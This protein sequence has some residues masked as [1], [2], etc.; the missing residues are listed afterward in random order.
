MAVILRRSRESGKVTFFGR[1]MKADTKMVVNDTLHQE[2]DFAGLYYTT[3]NAEGL[4]LEPPYNPATLQALVSRNNSLSQC[5]EVMEVNIDGT[6]AT[7]EP[8]NPEK[9]G[10][11]SDKAMLEAFFKE[12]APAMDM[13]T[14]RKA[15]RW[16]VEATG[17]AYVE[18]L[19]N[20]EGK[21][22]FLR[23]LDTT[24]M[25][26]LKLDDPVLVDKEVM[27]GTERIKAKVWVRERRY[28]QKV[29][30]TKLYFK[31]FGASRDLN[32]YTGQW[33][34]LN[35]LP[36]EDRAS[37]VYHFTVLKDTKSPYG[38]PRWINNLPSV[39]GGRKSEEFNLQ[40]FDAGGVPPAAIFI[41]GGAVAK[42]VKEQLNGYFGGG[43][44]GKHRVALVEIESTSGAI[45]TPGNVGIKVERFGSDRTSDAM[46]Q[47][48]E[49]NTEQRIRAAFRLPAI[50]FGL[51][52][53]YNFATASMAY[54]VTEAQVFGPERN[55][56]DG[57]VNTQIV[58]KNFG[59]E[60]W[61]YVSTP[62]TLTNVD[63]QLVALPIIQNM[64]D[65]EELV[66]TVNEITGM[67]LEYSEETD[68]ANK[69]RLS[70]LMPDGTPKPLPMP[71]QGPI[72]DE[73]ATSRGKLNGASSPKAPR[74]NGAALPNRPASQVKKAEELVHLAA[75]W[76][77][78]M[79]GKLSLRERF[80]MMQKVEDLDD[81][82]KQLFGKLIANQMFVDPGIDLAGLGEL[83]H[84][85]MEA[86][87]DDTH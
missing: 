87:H 10:K 47:G 39:L 49:A 41:Q 35:S 43:A 68:Q 16:D 26:L 20:P 42:D 84:A 52:E 30:S 73:E 8:I 72:G 45:D 9:Q 25:R 81:D 61:K 37:E 53:S 34:P 22:I 50:F 80:S 54:M 63:A 79:G 19:T 69:N 3:K 6:G 46:F 64:V 11:E 38:I 55:E 86:A 71:P 7:I 74:R 13:M 36:I 21:I 59:I 15:L 78:S 24:A 33:A 66:K 76:K 70:G 4:I 12:V 5:I 1:M 77:T 56:F 82:E 18:I 57:F 65:G 44:T 75:Q 14:L 83:A 23:Y 62:I 40:F 85:C 60:D 32:R 31:E 28:V 58:R 17:N 67:H 48:F 2:D 29:G 51:E 27:R